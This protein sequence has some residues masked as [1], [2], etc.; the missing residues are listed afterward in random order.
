[1]SL[2]INHMIRHENRP[3]GL[4]L[5]PS[6]PRASDR[7]DGTLASSPDRQPLLEFRDNTPNDKATRIARRLPFCD[8]ESR[9]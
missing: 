4:L 5:A 6:S 8:P 2:V 3:K 7:F 9:A 1:M